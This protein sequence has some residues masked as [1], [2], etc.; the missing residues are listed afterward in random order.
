MTK[1]QKRNKQLVERYPFLLPRNVF[2]D[3]LPEDYDYSYI[4]GIGELPK[5]WEKLFLQMCED[6]R[7]PLIDARQLETFRFMQ[8]KEKYNCMECYNN[9]APEAVHEIID[10]YS[11]MAGYICTNCGRPATYK[12]QGYV[13]SY[14]ADCFKD[15]IKHERGE[16]IEPSTEYIV[17]GFKAGRCY[18]K[19]IS[20]K[21]EWDNYI[22]SLTEDNII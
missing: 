22:N 9:G 20:F 19:T 21:H 18:T 15:S 7:Q 16:W 11:I 5:G 3:E 12:T 13:A 1:E 6:I 4:R 2:T 17:H 10:K 14:C 8:I